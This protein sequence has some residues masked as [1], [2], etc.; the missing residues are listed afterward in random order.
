MLASGLLQFYNYIVLLR[1][2]SI[3]FD[4]RM[5]DC[6]GVAASYLITPIKQNLFY[7][8]LCFFSAIDVIIVIKRLLFSGKYCIFADS[9]VRKSEDVL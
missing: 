7:R 4:C 9:F 1:L 8:F 3:S 5:R 6:L 2:Q